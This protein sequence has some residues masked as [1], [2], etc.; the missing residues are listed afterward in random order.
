M[1]YEELQAY[2]AMVKRLDDWAEVSAQRDSLINEAHEAGI[3]N[4]QIAA[5]MKISRSTVI[6]VLGADDNTEEG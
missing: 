2:A 4:M 1:S 6:A 3:P 5:H